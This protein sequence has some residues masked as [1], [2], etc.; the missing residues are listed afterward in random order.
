MS[1]LKEKRV[2][3]KRE[4]T[5]RAKYLNTSLKNCAKMAKKSLNLIETLNCTTHGMSL[6]RRIFYP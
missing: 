6:M 4:L 5:L 1:V 3:N 2:L